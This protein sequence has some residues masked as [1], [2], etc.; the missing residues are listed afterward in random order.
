MHN[1][2]PA[3]INLAKGLASV[4]GNRT[5]FDKLL[6]KFLQQYAGTNTQLDALLTEGKLED[7]CRL[8]HSI[9][10]VAGSLGA[11]KLFSA[12]QVL[13]DGLRSGVNGDVPQKRDFQMALQEIIDALTQTTT[14][15]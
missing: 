1:D 10:G 11:E 14:P 4:R 12:A 15:I 7:A 2:I 8:V 3:G 13:E 9:K 5:L 6:S